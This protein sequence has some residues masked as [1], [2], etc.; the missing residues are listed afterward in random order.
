MKKINRIAVLLLAALTL[1]SCSRIVPAEVA[2][3]GIGKPE[4]AETEAGENGDQ[5]RTELAETE[6]AADPAE[7]AGEGDEN[8][9]DAGETEIPSK[10]V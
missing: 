8:K 2:D 6:G 9:S 1:A 7:P 3:P 10:R 4:P 5:G